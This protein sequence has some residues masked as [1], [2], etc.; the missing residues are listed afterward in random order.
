MH[1]KMKASG[2]QKAEFGSNVKAFRNYLHDLYKDQY[3]ERLKAQNNTIR[4]VI[5]KKRKNGSQENGKENKNGGKKK[6]PRGNVSKCQNCGRYHVGAGDGC[7]SLD[8]NKD[9]RPEWYKKPGMETIMPV[10]NLNSN[11]N[12]KAKLAKDNKHLKISS[13]THSFQTTSIPQAT[14]GTKR[15][16]VEFAETAEIADADYYVGCEYANPLVALFEG[17]TKVEDSNNVCDNSDSDFEGYTLPEFLNPFFSRENLNKKTK[18]SH[19]AAELVVEILDKDGK[20][21]P[22]RALIDTGATSSVI[23]R[24]FVRKGRAGGYKGKPTLWKTMGGNFTT[25][26]KALIDF[27]FP[28][29]DMEKKVTWVFH[30]DENSKPENTLYDMII[31]LDLQ[32]A[33]G[34]Y[35]NTEEKVIQ[36]GQNI[37]PLGIRG[38]LDEPETLTDIYNVAQGFN[39]TI[40]AAEQQHAKILDADYSAVNIEEHVA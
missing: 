35:V 20:L 31:G 11:H 3:K 26:K 37:T 12:I 13:N 14:E 30:V 25:K 9:N 38:A 21:V 34:I 24:D 23:L 32:T 19:Y 33:L 29:L 36:W 7:W 22:I 15:K 27:K 2:K 8:K 1:N 5:E 40:G 6:K 4:N 17:D 10:Q 16:R 39:T 18:I 28:E